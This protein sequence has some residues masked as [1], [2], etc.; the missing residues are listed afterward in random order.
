ML[1]FDQACK[2]LP[3]FCRRR[4]RHYMLR[5]LARAEVGMEG[6]G[7][8]RALL[9]L[10]RLGGGGKVLFVTV[11][12][13]PTLSASERESLPQRLHPSARRYPSVPSWV[14]I[15]TSFPQMKVGPQPRQW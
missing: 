8:E 2:R 5:C 4:R 3:L 7:R 1:D 6:V 10:A 14:A 11:H 13:D 12:V 9:L 15:E